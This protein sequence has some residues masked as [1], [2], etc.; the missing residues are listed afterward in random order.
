MSINLL[1]SGMKIIVKSFWPAIAW[2][3]LS[4]IAFCLPGSVLPK[5]EWLERIYA[6]KW[7]HIG[8]FAVIVFLWCA[9]LINRPVQKSLPKLFAGIAIVFFG[10]GVLMEFVQHFFILNRSF[11]LGDIGADAIGCFVGYFLSKRQWKA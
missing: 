10:Y 11:D 5:D 1:D 4:T 7:T 3:I 6:D 9:P 8:L 2:L